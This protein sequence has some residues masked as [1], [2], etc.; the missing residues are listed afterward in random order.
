MFSSV[1]FKNAEACQLIWLFLG[2]QKP[3]KNVQK[4]LSAYKS[5]SGIMKHQDE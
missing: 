1:Y 2:Q 3:M 4:R 5:I